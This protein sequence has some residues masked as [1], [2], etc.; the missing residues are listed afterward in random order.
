MRTINNLPEV[1][2]NHLK[3]LMSE[4]G[5]ERANLSGADLHS[6]DLS[7]ANLSGADLRHANLRHAD[8]RHADL[9]YADLRYAD[10]HEAYLY[11]ADLR[12]ANLYD[13]NLSGA[14]LS[15]ADLYDANLSGADL[16]GADGLIAIT[17]IGS[18]GDILLAIDH[19]TTIY[20]KT[21][22]FWGTIAE[23]ETAVKTTHGD[24]AHA[25]AYRAAIVLI[26]VYFE[27]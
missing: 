24:N 23:F 13:A 14:D 19:S 2:K 9:R 4:P 3:W 17:P 22:C 8:L 6:A 16:S 26:K 18:R 15:G 12:H 7:D 20:I 10:L 5:G 27:E 25:K 1:L 11:G 21:G